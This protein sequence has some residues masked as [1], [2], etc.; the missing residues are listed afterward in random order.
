M[1][2]EWI[3][4]RGRGVISDWDLEVR[5]Q[6]K[7]DSKID[8]LRNVEVDQAGRVNLP[9]DLLAGPGIYGQKWIYKMKIHGSVALR[10]MLA[11]GPLNRDAEWTFLVQAVE[12]GRKLKPTNAADIA[13]L[14]RREILVDPS[15]R[16]LILDGDDESEN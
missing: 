8:M 9:V 6:A 13:E 1:V 11:L 4:A 10:P 12:V 3:D 2:F 15:R 14:R 16:R 5:Q 7:L